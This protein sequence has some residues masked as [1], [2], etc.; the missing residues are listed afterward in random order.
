MNPPEN[1]GQ[2]PPLVPLVWEEGRVRI[3]DQRLLPGREQYVEARDAGAVA[4]AII[5]M[6]LRG[7][8]LIGVAAAYG[9]ALEARRLLDGH[10]SAEFYDRMKQTISH[11]LGC[12]PTAVN[13]MRALAPPARWLEEGRD[14]GDF[15]ARCEEWAHGLARMEAE[16]CDAMGRLGADCLK[17]AGR[18]LTHCNTGRLAT[19]GTGTALAVVREAVRR[20]P[21]YRVTCT[22]TRPWLQ[23]ARLTAYE[24]SRE[25]IPVDLVT[26][27]A[28]GDRLLDHAI[29][30]FI[31]G[32]DRMSPDGRVVNKVGTHMLAQLARTGGARTMVVAPTT[33][34]DWEWD[35]AHPAI[36]ERR[37]G[38]ELWAATGCPEIPPGIQVDNP[39]FDLTPPDLIDWIVTEKGVIAPAGGEGFDPHRFASGLEGAWNRSPVAG[40]G[41]QVKFARAASSPPSRDLPPHDR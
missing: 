13:L 16:A 9:V 5:Q 30:Y 7:A 41:N 36:L 15:A 28:A 6:R 23:G 18:I 38:E 34:I 3:L 19:V 14:P 4:D 24:L 20:D 29:D 40:G 12:R 2:R 35:P 21:A 22:E 33:T 27:S 11:L 1:A 31:V 25:G 10:R 8:P 26:E 39:V 32:A 37:S 17:A